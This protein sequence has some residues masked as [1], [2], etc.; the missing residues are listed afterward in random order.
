[1]LY[2]SRLAKHTAAATKKQVISPGGSAD[3]IP[4]FSAHHF[5]L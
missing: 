3:I 5:F 4:R 2:F 1:M